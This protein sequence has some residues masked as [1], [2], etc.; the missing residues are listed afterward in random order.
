MLLIP[1]SQKNFTFIERTKIKDGEIIPDSDYFEDKRN[2]T[3]YEWKN[4]LNWADDFETKYLVPNG[5]K[6]YLVLNGNE[7][8]IQYIGTYQPL[9][10]FSRDI[11]DLEHWT[12]Q[13]IEAHNNEINID[14][15]IDID[16][17]EI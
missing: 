17:E 5:S 9:R 6:I 16:D 14:V 8:D 2:W 12:Y 7:N 1:K 13:D 15:E 10:E 11:S 3:Y 4:E